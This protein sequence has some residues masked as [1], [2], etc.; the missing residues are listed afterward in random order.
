MP[1][2]TSYSVTVG[3]KAYDVTIEKSSDV[4]YRIR[5][6][7]RQYEVDA[8]QV[9]GGNYSVL[10]DGR[11]YQACWTGGGSSED[12][13]LV[14]IGGR[15]WGV[16]VEGAA[17]K[18]VARASGPVRAASRHVVSAPIPGKIVKISIV[19]GDRVTRGQALIVLEAMKME[20]EIVTPFDGVAKEIAVKEGQTVE[21]GAALVVIE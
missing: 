10:I 2:G 3:D 11:S 16:K 1:Q 5:V 8:R 18:G 17:R 13:V 6:N 4:L 15:L 14:C 20:N 12:E 21:A 7:G 9:E 19:Q